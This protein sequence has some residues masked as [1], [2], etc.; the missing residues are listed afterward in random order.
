M[1]AVLG[2]SAGLSPAGAQASPCP[3]NPDALGVARVITLDTP[4]GAFLGRLQYPTTLD[5]GPK[6]IVLTFDDGPHNTNTEAILAALAHHCTRAIFFTIG[7]KVRKYPDIFRKL[8]QSSHT[9]AAHSWSHP[10]NLARLPLKDAIREIELGFQ[11]IQQAA[12]RPVAP[13][14]RF[15]GLNESKALRRYTASR[16]LAVFSTDLS[17]DDWMQIGPRTIIARTI[18]RIKRRGRGILIFHDG[19][20]A[21][22]RALPVILD[23]LSRNHY[24]IVHVVPK[25]G[26]REAGEGAALAGQRAPS[27]PEPR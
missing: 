20:A 8:D 27:A 25:Q 24:R 26:Y 6:E 17:S 1:L 23:W 19:S 3:H 16:G 7:R 10:R 18:A 14:F 2:L 13:F 21:T 11:T 22:V 4:Q 9:L 15:P 5:L 12:T